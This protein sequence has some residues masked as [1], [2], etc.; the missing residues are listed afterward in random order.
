MVAD[1]N[2]RS[3]DRVTSGPEPT[4]GM[5]AVGHRLREVVAF[6]NYYV[7]A[8]IDRAKLTAINI[9]MFAV[10][11]LF[12]VAIGTAV[13]FTA[14]VLLVVGLSNLLGTVLAF[15]PWLFWIGYL[16]VPVLILGGLTAGVVIGTKIVTKSTR[17]KMAAAYEQRKHE[18]RSGLGTDVEEQSR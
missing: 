15:R 12:A 6:G 3:S 8:Q 1:A 18:Q 7:A 14:A 13:V 2:S 10:L 16:I 17:G 9:G 4:V 5:G 11:G